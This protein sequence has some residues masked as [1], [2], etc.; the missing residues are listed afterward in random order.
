[1]ASAPAEAEGST[2]RRDASVAHD[3]VRALC[4]PPSMPRLAELWIYPVKSMAGVRVARAAVEARGLAGDRRFMVV[5]PAG[6]FLTQRELPPMA[7]LRARLHGEWLHL[8]GPDGCGSR[9]PRVPSGPTREVVVWDH[10]CAAVDAGDEVAAW[11]ERSLGRPARLVYMPDDVRRPADLQHAR[12]G[13][14]VSFAD[15]FPFLLATDAS[16]AA[17]NAALPAPVDLRRFRPNLVLHGVEAPFAEDGWAELRIGELRFYPR[18]PCSRCPIVDVDPDAGERAPGV[19]SAL[20][21]LR[22]RGNRVDFGQNLVHEGEGVL[23]EGAPVEVVPRS[24]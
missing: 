20:S 13:D 2:N 17:V 19:L 8:E 21:T 3:D 22:R 1:M 4:A 6:R 9:V 12:Q 10:R 15:G 5:D 16:L 11:L 24:P 14:L 23:E 7:R 18:K